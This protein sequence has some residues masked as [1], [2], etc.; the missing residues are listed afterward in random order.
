MK[1]VSAILLAL[2]IVLALAVPAFAE[3]NGSITIQNTLKD[4][5]YTLYKI[6][7]LTYDQNGNVSYTFLK[8][9]DEPFNSLRN[10]ADTPFTL[11]ETTTAN[12]YNVSMKMNAQGNVPSYLKTLVDAGKFT[13]LRTEVA[14]SNTLTFSGLPYGY[15]YI[16]SS[17]GSAVTIS[18]T[19]PHASLTD[20]NEVASMIKEVKDL[21]KADA[22]YGNRAVVQIGEKV[23]YRLSGK[24]ARYT[25]D[26]RKI[27]S[28]IFTDN[29]DA[30]LIFDQSV[31]IEVKV[32][33]D[34]A[35]VTLVQGT[36]YTFAISNNNGFRL[37]LNNIDN[38]GNFK[39]DTQADY[40]ITYT[41][42]LNNKAVVGSAGN[43]NTAEMYSH[44]GNEDKRIVS[45]STVVCTYDFELLKY[46]GRDKDKSPL[47]GAQFRL[48]DAMTG[49][50]EIKV[51]KVQPEE[52]AAYYRVAT[53]DEVDQGKDTVIEAG[54]V[55]IRGLDSEKDYYLE[56]IK[57]PDGYN[58]LTA[59][60][61][62]RFTTAENGSVNSLTV[63]VENNTGSLLPSTGGIGTTIFYVVGGLLMLAAVVLF[64]ARRKVNSDK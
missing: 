10:D 6:F 54:D 39:F 12:L 42:I 8:E 55:V 59:R 34:G 41:A 57:A 40:T 58:V 46:D 17:L 4:Q 21:N 13:A 52:G 27:D 44:T 25:S 15:Y 63:D 2:V 11:T 35:Y 22:Q 19:M 36:D 49:G 51:V 33:K 31:P 14:T 16:S 29:M 38:E 30:G 45:A 60:K 3:G 20:K 53:D 61:L 56:E 32:K 43:K 64:A 18:S 1:R 5:T 50:N 28:Y 26:G 24:I 23:E 48:Y 62:V 9:G 37:V 7:D 47:A